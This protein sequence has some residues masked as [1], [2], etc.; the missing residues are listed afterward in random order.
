MTGELVLTTRTTID[1]TGGFHI[2]FN[3]VPSSVRGTG[4]SGAA[5]K[6]MGGEREHFNVALD[7]APLTDTFTSVFNL[8]SQGSTD[9]FI[10]KVTFHVTVN[11][12]GQVTV[13]FDKVST[14]CGG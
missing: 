13:F 4:A 1:A 11:A 6:A 7:D 5:Y 2:A 9:N 12:N 8:V 10:A 14:A 3:L